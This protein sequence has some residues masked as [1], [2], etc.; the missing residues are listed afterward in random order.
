MVCVGEGMIH[1]ACTWEV[2]NGNCLPSVF[3]L[4]VLISMKRSHHPG[5]VIFKQKIKEAWIIEVG[6]NMLRNKHSSC[7]WCSVNWHNPFRGQLVES[8]LD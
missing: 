1:S 8:H 5:V 2:L 4:A 7:G 3:S 6:W